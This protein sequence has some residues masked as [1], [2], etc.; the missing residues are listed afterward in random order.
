MFTFNLT[1]NTT[2]ASIISL[3]LRL[4]VLLVLFVPVQS[5]ALSSDWIHADAVDA[6]L[7]SGVDGV[8]DESTITL[9]LEFNLADGW[10]TYWRSPGEAGLPPQLDSTR[11]K[12]DTGNLDSIT[13]HYPAPTRYIAYGLETVGYRDHVVFH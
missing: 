2:R 1:K 10:H 4:A 8:G 5:F 3:L 11:S 9:G 7:I 12:T 13:L 6:R